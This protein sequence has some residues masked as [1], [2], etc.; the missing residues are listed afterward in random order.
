M[1]IFALTMSALA[2]LTLLAAG[3]L[4]ARAD[5]Q[6]AETT[7]HSTTP[8]PMNNSLTNIGFAFLLSLNTALADDAVATKQTLTLDGAKKAGDAA[9]A[10]AKTKWRRQCYRSSR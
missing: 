7:K 8:V 3:A 9:A 1:L 2:A 10:Y 6:A 4:R 5:H